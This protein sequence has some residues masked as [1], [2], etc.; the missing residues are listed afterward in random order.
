MSKTMSQILKTG[1]RL[2]LRR[3]EEA[4]LNFILG[5]QAAP[6]NCELVLPF[7]REEH[8]K[9]LRGDEEVMDVIVE[10]K[11]TGEAVGYLRVAGL[12]NP[13]KEIEWT[14]VIIAKKGR[15]YGHEAMKLIKAW[16]FETKKAHRAWL[17]CKEYNER[18]LHLYE[19]EG[20]KREGLIRETIFH[21]GRYE[22]LVILGILDREY[23]AR[24]EQGLE[25][26]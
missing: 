15:G 20:L 12:N 4:D 5:L 10:E 24:K 2:I 13:H 14:H 23:L 19:A 6:D 7:D 17:D 11:A 26:L 22:N 21:C 9:A 16:T 3:G 18:A 25:R 8:L 1:T